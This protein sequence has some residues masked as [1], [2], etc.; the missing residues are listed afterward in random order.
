MLLDIITTKK[1]FKTFN[2]SLRTK[3]SNIK[4]LSKLYSF[5]CDI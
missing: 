2:K 3:M 4:T 1:P 5:E